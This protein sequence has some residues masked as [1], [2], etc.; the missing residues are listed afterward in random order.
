VLGETVNMDDRQIAQENNAAKADEVS[1]AFCSHGTAKGLLCVGLRI[2]KEDP[3]FLG[4]FVFYSNPRWENNI[5][6]FP[7]LQKLK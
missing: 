6:F 1:Q 2:P 4:K 7:K 3:D 5:K